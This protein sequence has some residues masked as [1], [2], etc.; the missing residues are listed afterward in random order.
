VAAVDPDDDE[1]DRYVVRR[2]AHD[3]Q[4]HERR[5]QVV[6]AFDNRAECLRVLETLSRDMQRRGNAGEP[7]DPQEHYSGVRL[8]PGYCRRQRDGRMLRAA[9]RR[10]VSLPRELV[11]RLDLPVGAKAVF[12]RS[13]EQ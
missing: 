7:I 6:A 12:S 2:Y 8:E 11:E 10:R 9:I 5:H 1:I 3:P 4:R 13:E